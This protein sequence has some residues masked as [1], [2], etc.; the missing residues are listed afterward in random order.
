MSLNLLARI[1]FFTALPATEL[2]RLVA[3]LDVVN[4]NSGDILFYE[5]HEHLMLSSGE[6]GF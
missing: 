2:D 6:L 5:P 4:L 3:E 1:P